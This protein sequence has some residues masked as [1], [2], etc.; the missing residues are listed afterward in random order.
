M[1]EI[2]CKSGAYIVQEGHNEGDMFVIDSGE[3]EIIKGEDNIV[4]ILH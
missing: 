2:S 3:L 1:S 4:K